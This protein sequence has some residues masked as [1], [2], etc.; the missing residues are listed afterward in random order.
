MLDG[1]TLVAESYLTRLRAGERHIGMYVRLANKYGV[2]FGR[3]VALTGLTP[4]HISE[5]LEGGD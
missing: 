3:I 2:P 1:R 5:L 4:A